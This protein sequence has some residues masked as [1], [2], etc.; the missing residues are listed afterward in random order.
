M[1]DQ[2]D[3]RTEAEPVVQT[4]YTSDESASEAVVRALAVVEDVEPTELGPLYAFI[5]TEALDPILGEP[6]ISDEPPTIVE[7]SVPDFRVVVSSDGQVTILD[8]K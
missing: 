6:V 4:R 3:P 1:A 7:F 2:Y 5:D 8:G